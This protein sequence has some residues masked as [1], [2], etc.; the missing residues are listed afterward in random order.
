[1]TRE[2]PELKVVPVDVFKAL[3]ILFLLSSPVLGASA[4]DSTLARGTGDSSM[5]QSSSESWEAGYIGTGFMTGG[6]QYNGGQSGTHLMMGPG[7]FTYDGT[8]TLDATV[9]DKYTGDKSWATDGGVLWDD[10][11]GVADSSVNVTDQYVNTRYGGFA[12]S[13]EVSDSK[14]INNA[15]MSHAE[16]IQTAGAALFSKDVS[17]GV[18]L[19]TGGENSTIDYINNGKI[20]E[21]FKSGVNGTLQAKL[22]FDWNDFSDSWAANLSNSSSILVTS[23]KSGT[24][25]VIS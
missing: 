25:G 21:V 12:Q 11:L 3:V 7:N 6:S 14:F 18:T 8:H 19:G 4:I 10:S 23:G 16:K 17:Y 1:M 5:W 15:N 9:N 2:T 22:Q 20:H 13:A 24:S